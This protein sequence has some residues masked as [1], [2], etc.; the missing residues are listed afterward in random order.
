[1]V[2]YVPIINTQAPQSAVKHGRDEA[3]PTPEGEKRGR[4]V[5]SVKKPKNH[6]YSYDDNDE[7]EEEDEDDDDEPAHKSKIAKVR[8]RAAEPEPPAASKAAFVTPG[9]V[10]VAPLPAVKHSN[11]LLPNPRIKY[12]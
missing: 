10:N 12:G 4:P 2:A 3:R 5:R 8:G 7:D 6:N 1:M 11:D 9:N